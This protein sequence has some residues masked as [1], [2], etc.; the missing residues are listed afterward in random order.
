MV[1]ERYSDFPGLGM[2]MALIPSLVRTQ[3]SQNPSNGRRWPKTAWSA[4]G[5]DAEAIKE[6]D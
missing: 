1:K 4:T 6:N 2:G 3:L 5:K